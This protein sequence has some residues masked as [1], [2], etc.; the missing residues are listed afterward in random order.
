M[1]TAVA[2]IVFTVRGDYS[3][4]LVLWSSGVVLIT[5]KDSGATIHVGSKCSETSTLF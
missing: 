1:T 3:I 4:A 2:N 5:G